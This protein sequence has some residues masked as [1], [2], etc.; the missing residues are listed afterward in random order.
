TD[1]KVAMCLLILIAGCSNDAD[2]TIAVADVF[3]APDAV[4]TVA[5]VV[6][7]V[8]AIDVPVIPDPGPEPVDVPTPPEDIVVPPTGELESVTLGDGLCLSGIDW[9]P[10]TDTIPWLQDLG[11]KRVRLQLQ[12]HRVEPEKGTWKLDLLDTAV[13]PYVEAG[14]EVIGVLAYGNPWATVV[15]G[16]DSYFPPDDPADFASYVEQT[17]GHLAGRVSW[18]EIW[19]E[20]NAGYRFWKP[21]LKGDPVAFGALVIAATAAGR[22]VCPSCQ[23]AFG[24]TFFHSQFIDGHIP[25]LTMAQDAHPDLAEHYDA[26]AIHPYPLY[27]PEAPPEG[28]V[29]TEEWPFADMVA[30]VRDVMA[31]QGARERP[32]WATEFGWPVF[33]AVSQER[34]A[35]YLIR[36]TLHMLALGAQTACWYNIA[37]GPDAGQFPPEDDFGLL[38]S[39]KPRQKKPSY[40]AMAQLGGRFANH[41]IVRDLRVAGELAEGLWGY[42]LA[43]VGMSSWWVVWADPAAEPTAAG[44]VN[45]V[46]TLDFKGDPADPLQPVGELPVYFERPN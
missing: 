45:S 37:D 31:A 7:D 6:P 41:R 39:D 4:V 36:G 30:G 32:M 15:E 26:M 44:I 46:Q 27:P 29:D 1:M 3:T 17:V 25:F 18:F 13:D 11:V 16:A 5:D 28:L 34:Q 8:S 12:W 2:E 10:T 22:S 21:D 24:G 19:N 33:T 38:T 14:I 43:A 35:A 9:F 20:P 23:F 42:E 40:H